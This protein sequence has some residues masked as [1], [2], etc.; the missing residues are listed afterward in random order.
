MT[1]MDNLYTTKDLMAYLKVSRGTLDS[2]RR[3]GLLTCT[4]IGRKIMYT[5]S[6]IQEYL[7][8]CRESSK[9]VRSTTRST[10]TRRR[11]GGRPARMI[12]GKTHEFWENYS[13]SPTAQGQPQK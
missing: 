7:S 12:V 9:E 11:Q 13:P 4:R 10:P 6:D 2:I 1:R 3:S 5:E 8:K